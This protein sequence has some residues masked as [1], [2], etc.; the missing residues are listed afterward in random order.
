MA[1]NPTPSSRRAFLHR[2]SA[3]GN[4]TIVLARGEKTIRPGVSAR[5]ASRV[6]GAN[7]RV[8]LGM[9]GLRLIP[10][11]RLTRRW[12]SAWRPGSY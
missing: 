12:K 8:H 4:A 11:I 3:L 5:S 7:D 10:K 6:L 1:H 9:I 2:A